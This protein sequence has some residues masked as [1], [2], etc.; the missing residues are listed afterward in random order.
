MSVGIRIKVKVVK[1][2]VAAPFKV[3][4]LDLLF[5]S[6]ID[7]MGCLV[8]AALDLG[9]VVRR[10]SWY[11]FEDTN[12]AQG[13]YNAAEYLKKDVELAD[14]IASALQ[15]KFSNSD[16]ELDAVLK[17]EIDSEEAESSSSTVS[18]DPYD[19]N[20]VME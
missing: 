12:F 16:E 15:M 18:G 3:V 11:S 6:G 7:R 2:K 5:G 19:S 4:N 14:K 8:D 17:T 1:N 13:R 10:G 9:I 20:S